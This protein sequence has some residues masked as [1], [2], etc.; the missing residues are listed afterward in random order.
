MDFYEKAIKEYMN[1]GFAGSVIPTSIGQNYVV[2]QLPN[3][4]QIR[5]RNTYNVIAQNRDLMQVQPST[6]VSTS[7]LNAGQIEYRVE[8][9]VCDCLDYVIL[10][11]NCTNNTGA[12]LVLAPAQMLIQRVEVWA[13]NGSKLLNTQYGHE[14]YLGNAFLARNEFENMAGGLGLNAS[15]Y[16][17]LATTIADGAST[18]LYIPIFQPFYS[19]KLHPSGLNGNLIIRVFFQTTALTH[20]SGALITTNSCVLQLRSRDQPSALT[21]EQ[22]K[23]YS[24]SIPMMLSF[25]NIQRMSQSLTLAPSSTYD[26]TLS[27]INGICPVLFWT[28]RNTALTASNQ[29]TYFAPQDFDIQDSSGQSLIGFNRRNQTE[30]LWDYAECFDNLFKKNVSFSVA[31]FSQSPVLDYCSGSVNGYELFTTYERLSF[32]TPASLAGGSYQI[33]IIAFVCDNLLI[34]DGM[35]TS[36]K[37]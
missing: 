27:G 15:T 1:T 19:T 23:F 6:T 14:L 24:G 21:T 25:M 33:D 31:V 36:M 3:R 28:I 8:S 29:N 30:Q 4:R 10:K 20:V 34:Q 2:T 22:S 32:T 17:N 5:K 9:G 35:V 11:L 26:I 13:Q 16:A 7:L 12:N 37:P 18:T